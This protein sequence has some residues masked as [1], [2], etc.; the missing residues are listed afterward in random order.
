MNVG[1]LTH[2]KGKLGHI[3]ER[4]VALNV[5]WCVL[6]S[7]WSMNQQRVC[8]PLLWEG[9]DELSA[10][11]IPSAALHG[12]WCTQGVVRRA[13]EA[14]QALW[15]SAFGTTTQMTGAMLFFKS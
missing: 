9:K 12:P 1:K 10:Y 7:A 13:C 2:E 6:D 11:S 8:C 4:R 3:D 5:S 14:V 15:R